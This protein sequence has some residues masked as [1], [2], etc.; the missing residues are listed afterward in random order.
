MRA[1]L[2]ILTR[3]GM[4]RDHAAFGE[5]R[6]IAQPEAVVAVAEGL[7]LDG[8]RLGQAL[9]DPDLK[10]RLKSE[11]QGAIDKGVFGSPFF[12]VDGEPF[13]GHDRLDD[14]ERW[15]ETGGW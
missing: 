6:S 8:G 15:L 13:W 5:G 7:G 1:S 11:V 3:E 10:E 9:K 4:G 12:L 2:Q 14:L